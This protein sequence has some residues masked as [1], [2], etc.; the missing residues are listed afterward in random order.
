MRPFER[1]HKNGGREREST[2]LLVTKEPDDT[3]GVSA[4]IHSLDCGYGYMGVCVSKLI[5]LYA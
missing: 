4:C 3:F 2:K 1:M 5:K